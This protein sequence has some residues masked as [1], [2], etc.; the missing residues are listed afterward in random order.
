MVSERQPEMVVHALEMGNA[1]N[2][3]PQLKRLRSNLYLVGTYRELT[4]RDMEKMAKLGVD[5]FLPQP[6]DIVDCFRSAT[7]RFG[8]HFRRH[9]RHSIT[10]EVGRLDG[11][12]VGKTI[13][14][15]EGG[16]L[17]QA[18][19]PVSKGESVLC[20]LELPKQEPLRVRCNVLHVEGEAPKAVQA[21]VQ[22]INLRG[23]EHQRLVSYL[24]ELDN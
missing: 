13:D 17:M 2:L 7:R 4:V 24:S 20:T 16:M 9:A 5:D 19:H 8:A 14:L 6:I 15:S 23:T 22:F 10:L 1:T 11:V 21:R 3:I 12:V 18:I